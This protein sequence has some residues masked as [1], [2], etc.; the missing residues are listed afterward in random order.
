MQINIRLIGIAILKT[1]QSIRAVDL[2]KHKL[3]KNVGRIDG[4]GLKKFP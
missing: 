3:L 2:L 1:D 4:W